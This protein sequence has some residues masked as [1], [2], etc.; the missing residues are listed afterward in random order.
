MRL[1]MYPPTF[2]QDSQDSQYSLDTFDYDSSKNAINPEAGTCG[3]AMGPS[4]PTD[5]VLIPI[6]QGKQGSSKASDGDGGTYIDDD[7]YTDDTS[8]S[9]DNDDTNHTPSLSFWAWRAWNR[10]YF[11]YELNRTNYLFLF[12]LFLFL[13][14]CSI[15][16]YTI[17]QDCC[18]PGGLDGH[19]TYANTGTEMYVLE[20]PHRQL[21]A[22]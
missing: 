13:C 15:C 9:Y 4:L 5:G 20:P 2:P 21:Q 3:I 12:A 10:V 11:W 19:T 8:A 22:S 18:T 6:Y 1:A 14:S 17:Y 7:S 16:M